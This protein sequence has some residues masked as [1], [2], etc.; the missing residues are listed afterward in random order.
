[1]LTRAAVFCAR[2]SVHTLAQSREELLDYDSIQFWS[3]DTPVKVSDGSD[4]QV[5]AMQQTEE[6]HSQS[7][8]A[9]GME[10]KK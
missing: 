4:G 2:Q 8:A 5:G 7:C 6:D 1:M 3:G 9:V 10:E